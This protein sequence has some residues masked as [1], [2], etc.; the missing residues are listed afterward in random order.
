MKT[1]PFVLSFLISLWTVD[2]GYAQNEEIPKFDAAFQ[3]SF[4]NLNRS[5]GEYPV[6]IG[7]RFG[8]RFSS[9]LYLDGEALY[10]PENPA[11]NFGETLILGGIRSGMEFYSIGI[12]G[13]VRAGTVHFG[14][15]Q[16]HS[17]MD[18]LT[19]PAVDLGAIF[20][21][22]HNRHFFVR[23]DLGDCIIPFSG[24]SYIG[25]NG[26]NNLGTTH[27]L[28]LDFGIGIRF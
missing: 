7:G 8:Y 26:L 4:L 6:G 23:M 16:F 24:T 11:G 12:F 10:F 27:N 9:F 21:Y 19:H 20:E 5:L 2:T 28:W 15:R 3:V 1:A 14:G 13:K 18:V 25:A 22:F 17:R